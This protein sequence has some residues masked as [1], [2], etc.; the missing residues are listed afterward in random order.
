M[1]RESQSLVADTLKV[2]PPSGSR[3][4]LGQ[5]RFKAL[6]RP[7]RVCRFCDIYCAIILRYVLSVTVEQ[8][9]WTLWTQRH[10]LSADSLCQCDWLKKFEQLSHPIRCKTN[11]TRDFLRHVFARFPSSCICLEIYLI[12]SLCV[13][14]L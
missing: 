2:L 14:M 6:Y 5:T 12:D 11:T 8:F 9:F 4:Y 13:A 10:S 7:L 1:G 3:L